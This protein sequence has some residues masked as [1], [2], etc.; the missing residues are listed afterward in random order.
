LTAHAT[1]FAE[2]ANVD[3]G[4]VR[5]AAYRSIGPMIAKLLGGDVTDLLARVGITPDMP[6]EAM[7]SF[8]TGA[9]LLEETARMAGRDDIAIALARQM[10]WA[11]LG[12]LAYVVLHAPTLGTAIAHL[13]RFTVI[14]QRAGQFTLDLE[15]K[16]D[17]TAMAT[18]RYTLR[19][20]PHAPPRQHALFVLALVVRFFREGIGDPS[21]SPTSVVLPFTSPTR[22][23]DLSFFG[24]PV[25]YEGDAAA[26]EFPAA[27]LRREM[28]TADP[29]LFPILVRHADDC[30][31]RLPPLD[32]TALDQARHVVSSLVGNGALSIELVAARM[33]TS[34]RTIQRQ[35]K[36]AGSSF[37]Q[38]V[39][40]VRLGLAQ[41]HLLD[42]ATSLTDAAFL[43][44]YSD[45]SAFSRAFRRWTGQSP[46]DYRRATRP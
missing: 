3:R 24:A 6:A 18:L 13:R 22:P 41:Q 21:W 17:G 35:L 1:P 32:D 19:R 40:D 10:P 9:E 37:K 11:D 25:D 4:L 43:L 26:I 2:R 8:E 30:V 31:A 46:Q 28:V 36:L 12:V 5:A 16:H 15:T 29:G 38:L 23:C 45:L 34:P 44:G 39:D 7:M 14:Q 33:G 20:S 27:T 42:P